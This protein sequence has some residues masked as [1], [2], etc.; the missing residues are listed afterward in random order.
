MP[1]LLPR[2]ADYAAAFRFFDYAIF[3]DYAIAC[4][5]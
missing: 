4:Y 2:R 5:A 1:M 3:T